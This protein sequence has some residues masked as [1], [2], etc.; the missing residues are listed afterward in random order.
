VHRAHPA[1]AAVLSILS[2]LVL[3]SLSFLS[4][5]ALAKPGALVDP[6]ARGSHRAHD[7]RNA[8]A[9]RSAHPAIAGRLART[10]GSHAE[11]TRPSRPAPA[12]PKRGGRAATPAPLSAQSR[13]AVTAATIAA[14]LATPCQ[15][16][17]L[18]PE[19]SN[20]PLVRAAVLCLINFERAKHE[21]SPLSTNPRLERAAEEHSQELIAQNYFA[22]VSPSGV[23]PVDRIRA[24]GYIP[25]PSFGYVIGENLAWGTLSLSTPQAIVSA[26]I[27]SPGHL[28]NILEKQYKDTGIAVVPA[29]PASLGGGAQ[30]ATYAQEFGVILG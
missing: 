9:P 6:D 11:V 24:A 4:A 8:C 13:A 5:S 26:W 30:G 22:H 18:T 19:A 27:A 15:N 10:C 2:F 25:G 28:A 12:P 14:V 23:T 20:L 16:T 17:E 1:R 7:I 29:V 3:A 21:Q